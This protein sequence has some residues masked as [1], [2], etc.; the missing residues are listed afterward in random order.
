MNWIKTSL[1]VVILMI[2]YLSLKSPSG[3]VEIKVNDKIGHTLAY[4]VL[5]VN[6]GLLFTKNK[7]LLVALSAFILSA[8]LEYLQ[9]FIPGRSVDWKDLVA[10]A[11]GAIIG[12][13]VLL[14]LKEQIMN[15]L[16]KLKLVT[17]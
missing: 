10:N 17:G 5:T 7:W 4:C 3:G 11:S 16:R 2:I 6:A 9:G 8:T 15:L 12:L 13:I 1:V 14:F